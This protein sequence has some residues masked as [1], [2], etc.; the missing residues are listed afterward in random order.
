MFYKE[1]MV[2]YI[3]RLSWQKLSWNENLESP[4]SEVPLIFHPVFCLCSVGKSDPFCVVELS[5]DRL[6]THTVYKNLNPEWNKV[7]TLWVAVS[8]HMTCCMCD[9]RRFSTVHWGYIVF[10]C[11]NCKAWTMNIFVIHL[12]PQYKHV[13]LQQCSIVSHSKGTDSEISINI[14]EAT[15]MLS[16]SH[17]RFKLFSLSL[18]LKRQGKGMW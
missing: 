8:Q 12:F 14:T 1:S 17:L 15:Q 6:Q 11:I 3:P 2:L 13:L 18:I 5:N 9:C 16:L 10:G 4:T 7:F